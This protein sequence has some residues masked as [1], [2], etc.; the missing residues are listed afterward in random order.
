M[1]TA[2]ITNSKHYQND[3]LSG[4]GS[5]LVTKVKTLYYLFCKHPIVIPYMQNKNVALFSVR[6][7]IFQ[8]D[9][10]FLLVTATSMIFALNRDL[11]KEI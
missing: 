8:V 2:Y 10:L 6:A 4:H 11:K 1:S 3:T 5:R 9:H 7:A